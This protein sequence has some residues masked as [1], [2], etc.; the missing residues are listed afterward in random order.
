MPDVALRGIPEPLHQALKRAAA[1]NHRSLNGEIL[2]RL[3][4][5]V[6]TA[7]VDVERILERIRQRGE[8]TR[9][10]EL[11]DAALRTLEDTGRR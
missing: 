4:R 6:R 11:D 9:L 8:R 7:P 3:E 10:R 5:S 1:R 2:S